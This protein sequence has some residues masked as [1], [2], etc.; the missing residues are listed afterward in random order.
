MLG[1][2]H[3]EFRSANPAKSCRPAQFRNSFRSPVRP[4]IIT[5]T[6]ALLIATQR[7]TT[8]VFAVLTLPASPASSVRPLMIANGRVSVPPMPWS[9]ILF[10]KATSDAL[11]AGAAERFVETLAFGAAA[12]GAFCLLQPHSSEAATNATRTPKFRRFIADG[13]SLPCATRVKMP[14][15]C[16]ATPTVRRRAALR[17]REQLDRVPVRVRDEKLERTIRSFDRPAKDHIQ[18]LEVLLPGLQIVH[19]QCEVV[20]TRLR[21]QALDFLPAN[22]VQFLRGAES[23]PRAR[24]IKTRPRNL[25]EPQNLAI[26]SAASFH[27]THPDGNVIQFQS[28]QLPEGEQSPLRFAIAIVG[29]DDFVE[30]RPRDHSSSHEATFVSSHESARNLPRF[31]TSRSASS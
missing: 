11:S 3:L 13:R 4:S 20:P 30:T 24:E 25:L 23:K 12:S 16:V 7:T 22:D 5:T 19:A 14:D 1:G 31:G 2:E 29:P 21:N 27:V 15:I 10:I 26:E 8:F 17:T 28:F 6:D 9:L 18:R